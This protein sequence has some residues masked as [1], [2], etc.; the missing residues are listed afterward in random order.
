MKRALLPVGLALLVGG[1]AACGGS[2]LSG[3]TDR[4][5]TLATVQGTI[6]NPQDLS[7]AD[8]SSPIRVAIVWAVRATSDANGGATVRVA[9]DV[10]VSA[11]LPSNFR[12]DL[13]QLPPPEAMYRDPDYPSVRSAFGT[14]VAY[15]DLNNNGQLDLIDANATNTID[16]VLA[17]PFDDVVYYLEGDVSTV[18][19]A[20]VD[21]NGA[22]P[23]LGFSFYEIQPLHEWACSGGPII[24]A[25]VPP[26][27][28]PGFLWK[29]IDTPLTLTISDT[30]ALPAA[31]CR[32]VAIGGSEFTTGTVHAPGELPPTLPV[33]SDPLLACDPG[34]LSLSYYACTISATTLCNV[35]LTC[36][37]DEYSLNGPPPSGWPCPMN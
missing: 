24:A 30:P 33:K 23:R 27:P 16:R 19:D 36:I 18:A 32:T 7:L 2:G 25:E 21:D 13:T 11:Q 5:S 8:S 28:C 4:P 17:I 20:G 9:Q 12:L 1:G 35:S 10:A 15:Q 14:I 37:G 3:S 34:G 29:R 26:T 6:E 31:V 22:P